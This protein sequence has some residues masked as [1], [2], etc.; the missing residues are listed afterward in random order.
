MPNRPTP[1]R[2]QRLTYRAFNSPEDDAFFHSIQ[3]D[4]IAFQNSCAS[5]PRPA[6]LRFT[7]KIRDSILESSLLFVVIC[8]N[9]NP[10]SSPP[11]G[12]PAASSPSTPKNGNTIEKDSAPPKPIGTAFLRL[13]SPDMLY[14]RTTELGIDIISKYQGQGYGT[15]AIH[16]VLEWA[17]K[18]AGMHR[19]ELSV[20]GW[21]K[22]ARE[23]YGRI[24]FAEEGRKRG[25]LCKFFVISYLVLPFPEP[26]G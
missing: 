17:F 1:F 5:L 7:E 14:H 12:P 2:S 25:C 11:S 9:P 19:V 18:T 21:N 22:G 16:W 26:V 6:D 4:P 10:S 8:L 24:G 3:S 13:A 23:L 15:E 20:L